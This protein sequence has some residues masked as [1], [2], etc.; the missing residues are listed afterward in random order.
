M[1]NFL[2]EWK[3][4]IVQYVN[5]QIRLIK[6]GFIER[7]SYLM[8]YFIFTIVSLFFLLC[9]MLFV[10]LGLTEFFLVLVGSKMLG[11]LMTIGVYLLLF[12]LFFAMRKRF[13]R[14]FASTFIKVL[15]E[16]DEEV[17]DKETTE[18]ES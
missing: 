14:F 2:S 4:K 6:L 1:M 15:T 17:K 5:V 8:G 13:V 11:F 10:G 16:K 7:T 18:T 9:I 12:L 3:D